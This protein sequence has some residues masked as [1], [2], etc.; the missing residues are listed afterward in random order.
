[1][2]RLEFIEITNARQAIDELDRMRREKGI[3]QMK[4]AEILNDPDAG[5]RQL[6]AYKSGN[7]SFAYAI[8]WAN[9][10][11]F[12]LYFCKWAGGDP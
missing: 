10:H 6:R 2:E 3:S 9:A 12:K 1:M 5:M 8:K 7:C 11:G 4:M